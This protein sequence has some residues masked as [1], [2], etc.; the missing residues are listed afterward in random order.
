MFSKQQEKLK[1][2]I[3]KDKKTSKIKTTKYLQT[4]SQ[5]AL[6]SLHFFQH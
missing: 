2:K 3:F 6:L 5:K 4:K 1:K